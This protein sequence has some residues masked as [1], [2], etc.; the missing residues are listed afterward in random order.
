MCLSNRTYF[1]SEIGNMAADGNFITPEAIRADMADSRFIV[2][3][4]DRRTALT[5]VESIR[6]VLPGAS[7]LLA[8]EEAFCGCRNLSEL[9]AKRGSQGLDSFAQEAQPVPAAAVVDISTIELSDRQRG[10]LLHLPRID[11]KIGG[12][13]PGELSVWSGRTGAGKSTLV[14][15]GALAALDQGHNVFIYSGELSKKRA[16]SWLT[17][18]AAG[19]G[20]AVKIED[21]WSGKVYYEVNRTLLPLIDEWWRDRLYLYDNSIVGA[22]EFQSV[23]AAMQQAA[24]LHG[25]DVFVVDNLMSMDLDVTGDDKLYQ[26][27]SAFVSRLVDFSH[28]YNAHIHLVAHPKKHSEKEYLNVGVISGSSDI[29]N[30]A[31]NVF[32]LER[33]AVETAREKGYRAVLRCLKNREWGDTFSVGLDFDHTCR[34]FVPASK[35]SI[36]SDQNRVIA[37]AEPMGWCKQGTQEYIDA[38]TDPF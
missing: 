32:Y 34:R 26:A 15:Q 9:A 35:R 31:D 28:K 14:N 17:L 25:C 12:F 27:Q 30:K 7:I 37:E 36:L 22:N 16:K 13:Q 21:Q 18:Q 33:L 2:A 24:L 11:E 38:R 3:I 6:A 10:I 19:H 4:K 1:V 20:A 29:G 5:A 8:S 23:L